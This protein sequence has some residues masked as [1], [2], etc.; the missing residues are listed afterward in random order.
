MKPEENNT[1]PEDQETGAQAAPE[2]Q[3]TA[4]RKYAGKYDSVEALEKGYQ[5]LQSLYGQTANDI[6]GL[7]GQL[8]QMQ[9]TI[10]AGQQQA[11]QPQ[12]Q[13]PVDYDKMHRQVVSDFQ[14]GKIDE[15]A[16]AEQ[17]AD[18]KTAKLEQQYQGALAQQKEEFSGMLQQE[19]GKRDQQEA[20]KTF[21]AQNP[22]F[23]ILV[24]N[25]SLAQVI[26]DNPFVRDEYE[27]Y[28]ALKANSA[29][30]S[31]EQAKQEA[32]EAGKAEALK[33]IGGSQ[34]AQE[35]SGGAGQSV[36]APTAQVNV[37]GTPGRAELF[38]SG[39]AAFRN[40]GA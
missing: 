29:Q 9:E 15:V 1:P 40:A 39:L 26:Q 22:D 37:S 30:S 27:A 19:L 33:Q 35:V 21:V 8:K 2:D 24:D 31:L 7:K 34:P 18:I 36:T 5:N 16:M 3:E 10:A 28:H 38:Q 25:G 11:Q 6:G 12:Q 13:Q 32:F 14:Q 17:L 23:E 4:P 20:Y